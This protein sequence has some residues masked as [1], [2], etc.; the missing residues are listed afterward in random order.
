MQKKL[1]KQKEQE[2]FDKNR[3]NSSRPVFRKNMG[4]PILSVQK[5]DM[6]E[7]EFDEDGNEIINPAR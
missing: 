2:L 4:D 1:L 5:V 3:P 7:T 6:L